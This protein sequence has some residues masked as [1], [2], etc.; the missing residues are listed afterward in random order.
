M[1]MIEMRNILKFT[2]LLA[3][4]IVLI[5]IASCKKED[6]CNYPNLSA[7]DLNGS[8]SLFN[9]AEAPLDK[10]GMVVSILYS[11]P[12][13]SDTTD[14]DGNYSFPDLPFGNYTLQYVKQGY[15]T[16]LYSFAHN[17][18]CELT[19]TLPTFYLGQRSTTNITS[20]SAETIAAH[21]DI[22]L[23]I[24]PAAT[25]EQARYV[26]LFLK[27]ENDVSSSSYD[28]E[29]GILYTNDNSLFISLSVSDLHSFGFISGETVYLKAYGESFYSN[30]YYD[31][32]AFTPHWVFPN[33]NIV[34][35]PDV[36]FIVP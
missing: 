34:T 8:V 1:K 28:K 6:E 29:S 15:G 35:V 18:N 2:T 12:L 16:Y 22:N 36:E 20:L 7:A 19:N 5:S 26:R 24:N 31:F 14:A 11:N 3:F 10:S 25:D 33:L 21:V 23:T 13:I 32:D 9:D 27:N 4:G 30:E 17:D